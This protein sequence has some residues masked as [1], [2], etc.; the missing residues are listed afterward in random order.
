VQTGECQS[1]LEGHSNRVDNVVFSPDG[2]RVASGS[3]DKTVRVW[4]VQTGEC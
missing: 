1:T 3:H 2:S 4:D